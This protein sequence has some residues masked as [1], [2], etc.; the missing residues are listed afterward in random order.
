M[1]FVVGFG[2]MALIG[3]IHINFWRYMTIPFSWINNSL[4]GCNA[5]EKVVE[6]KDGLT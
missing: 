2:A 6:H 4:S 3:F 1:R 5:L